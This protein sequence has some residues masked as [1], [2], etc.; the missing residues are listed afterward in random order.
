MK[1]H[2]DKPE[3]NKVLVNRIKRILLEVGAPM[4]PMS[5]L[6]AEL[7]YTG[8]QGIYYTILAGVIEGLAIELGFEIT[9]FGS[10]I[11]LKKDTNHQKDGSDK[12]KNK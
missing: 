3:I 10:Q 6:F 2:K 11:V 9:K 8:L 1:V 12:E 7:G 4:I 5:V